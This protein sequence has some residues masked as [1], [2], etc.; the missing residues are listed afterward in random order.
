M[1]DKLETIKNTDLILTEILKNESIRSDQNYVDHFKL[2]KYFEKYG[3]KEYDNCTY[4]ECGESDYFMNPFINN[5]EQDEVFKEHAILYMKDNDFVQILKST[6][7]KFKYIVVIKLYAF[8]DDIP[9]LYLYKESGSYKINSHPYHNSCIHK[10]FSK[11]LYEN[12]ENSYPEYF[13]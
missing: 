3:K 2:P 9:Y 12:F 7:D 10:D 11:A 6:T 4:Y 1:I 5:F 8:Y 13:I